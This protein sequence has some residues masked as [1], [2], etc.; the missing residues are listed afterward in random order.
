MGRA[1][2]QGPVNPKAF[3][4]F[5]MPWKWDGGPAV[6]ASRAWDEAGNVQPTALRIRRAARAD[7]GAGEEPAR[8]PEPALQQPDLV[9][10]GEQRGDFAC[11]HL[12][13]RFSPL[14]LAAEPAMRRH[15]RTS[16][17]RSARPTS[18]PGTSPSCPTAPTCRPAAARPRRARRSTRRNASRA[19][20]R[21][22]KGGTSCGAGRRRAA[23]PRHRGAEDHREFLA[24]CDDRLRLHPPRDAVAAAAHVHQRGGLRAHRLHTF[25]EQDDRRE[26]TTMDAETLPQV[27]MP[28]RDNFIV[29]FPEKM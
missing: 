18:A 10:R 21:G 8:L 4:R 5:H 7:E 16:A 20:A 24:E 1:A 2:L 15:A 29:R 28:N 6:I 19:M 13:S 12:G 9:G 23:R 3:T 27:R 14:L 25:A 22:G 11:L 26:T 17:S